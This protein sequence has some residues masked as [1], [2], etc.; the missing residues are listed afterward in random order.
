MVSEHRRI[1]RYLGDLGSY[2]EK[3]LPVCVAIFLQVQE[4]RWQSSTQ[5]IS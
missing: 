4:T 2:H 3:K 1:L 5:P